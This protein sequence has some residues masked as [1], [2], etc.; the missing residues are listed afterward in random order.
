MMRHIANGFALA[1]QF[2]SV[3]PV[4]KEVPLEKNDVT[5]MYGSLPLLGAMLG[6][7]SALAVFILRDYTAASPLLAAFAVVLV[8]AAATGGLHLD[9][10]ADAGD[11]FFSYQ[12]KEK[13]LEIMGDPR[14]GAFGALVLVFTI[15]GKIIVAA[16]LV[17][18]LPLALL[19][20]IP[21]LSRTGLLLLFST[22]KNAKQNGLGAFFRQR[23]HVKWLA[24]AACLYLLLAI[25]FLVYFTGFGNA[26]A[27]AAIF[28]LGLWLYRKWCLN[29]FGGVTGDLFGAYIEGAE[30][31]L[32]TMLLFF[33]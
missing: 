28:L 10:L 12:D 20:A 6:G 9:G 21:F 14:I 29:H 1:L 8:L 13:R 31:L 33:I 24:L 25:G 11:A 5:A 30:L 17:F 27:I 7:A 18:E 22:T 3:V 16:E 32:W 15:L 26:A 23:V 4:N 2:F 19:A